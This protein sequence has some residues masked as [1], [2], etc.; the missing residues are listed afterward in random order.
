MQPPTQIRQHTD[1]ESLKHAFYRRL[2]TAV[3]T[4]V[5]PPR[6]TSLAACMLIHG[7]DASDPVFNMML[8]LH[9]L[10]VVTHVGC[11]PFTGNIA[12]QIR[13]RPRRAV[14]VW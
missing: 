1:L 11:V 5:H 2:D 13:W 14:P 3:V 12:L 6:A 8:C 4:F 10:D 7:S 9:R